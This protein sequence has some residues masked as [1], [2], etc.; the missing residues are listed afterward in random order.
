VR[1]GTSGIP[2]LAFC[3][4]AF[5][6]AAAVPAASASGNGKTLRVTFQ[7]AETGFDPVRIADYY[8]G[9]VIEAVFEPLLTYDYLARPAKLVP[10]TAEAMPAVSEN[11]R[12]YTLRIRPGIHFADDPAFKSGKRELTAADYAYSIKRFMDPANRSPYA[13][14][15]EGKIAGLDDLAATAKKSGRFD[16]DAALAGLETLDR[17]TLRV[18]LNAPDFNFSHVLAFPLAGA[19]A[20][21]VIEAYGDDTNSHPVGTG[22]YR[23][24]SYVRSSKIVLEANP[25]Y[26]GKAWDFAAGSD[27]ADKAIVARMRGTKLPAI[28]TVEISVMDETQSRWLAFLGGQT[29]IEY[30]LSDLSGIFMSADGALK[31]EY[32]KRGLRL[33][34]SVDPEITYTYFNTQEKIGGKPNPVGGFSKERIALRRAIAMAYRIE[35]QVRIIR[36]GQ[37]VRAQFPIPPG[38]AGHDPD[39]RTGIPHDPRLANA[40]LDRYGYRKGTDGYRM[41]PDGSP[42]LIRYSSLPTE[43]YRQFDE[44]VKRSL[45]SIGVRVEIHKDRFPELNKLENECRLMMRSSAWIADYPDG[46]NFMQ[47]LYGPN[48]RQSNNACYQ[49]PEFDRRYERSRSLP[50]GPERNRLYREMARIIETDSVW[51]LADSRMRNVLLQP[52]VAGY[53]KHPVLHAEWLYLDLDPR[54]AK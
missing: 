2:G 11:G 21:E 25:G 51:I 26:R 13:F 35:D 29:D 45:D 53:R 30:Q 17:H 38:V 24:K 46:D 9:T 54:P 15:F 39:Y 50:D 16:Y 1:G 48:A 10:N 28:G 3:A 36:N 41:Q 18:R 22:P 23:L 27:P 7:A 6:L 8:S 14:L 44:L 42:L 32:A 5:A 12:V 19:V 49:S 20:R 40:L 33:D 31:P 52:Y 37:A 34:R 47:L 4:L 43:V